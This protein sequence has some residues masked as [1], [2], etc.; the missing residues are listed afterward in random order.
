[1]PESPW[2]FIYRHRN[3]YHA[4]LRGQYR[5]EAE[6]REYRG[7]LLVPC[8]DPHN[9]QVLWGWWEL[10]HKLSNITLLMVRAEGDE[11]AESY[12]TK[13]AELANWEFMR[14]TPDEWTAPPHSRALIEY[15]NSTDG[16]FHQPDFDALLGRP[17]GTAAVEEELDKIVPFRGR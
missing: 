14:A 10:R 2:K 17:M 4:D 9:D 12:C 6:A 11:M 3:P 13:V 8:Y 15:L 1:M 5:N 16:V 7:L